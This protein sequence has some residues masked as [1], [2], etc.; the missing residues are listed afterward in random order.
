MVAERIRE[1]EERVHPQPGATQG[2]VLRALMLEHGL[3]QSDLPEIGTQSVV[4]ELLSAKR[5]LNL[6]QVKALAE[7]FRVPIEVLLP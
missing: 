2:H 7:R 1:F 5:T 3:S 4:S 6:R